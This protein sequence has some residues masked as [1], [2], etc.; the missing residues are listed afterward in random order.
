ML[1]MT[2]LPFHVNHVACFRRLKPYTTRT[3]RCLHLDL[4]ERR[5]SD[6]HVN[7]VYPPASLKMQT[8]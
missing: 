7:V 5:Q 8:L 4:N 1:H 2:Y 3:L 6:G